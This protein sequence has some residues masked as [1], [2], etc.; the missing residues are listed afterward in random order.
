M[1][2][3]VSFLRVS[4]PKPNMQF[5]FPIFVPHAPPVSPSLIWSPERYLVG[6]TNNEAPQCVIYYSPL[7]LPLSEVTECSPAPCDR[8]PLAYNAPITWETKFHIRIIWEVKLLFCVLESLFLTMTKGKTKVSE[9]N[10]PF[11]MKWTKNVWQKLWNT[12]HREKGVGNNW[13][14]NLQK[15]EK[16]ASTPDRD[17]RVFSWDRSHPLQGP[18]S[19]VFSRNRGHFLR[20]LS[21]R[22][23]KLTLTSIWCRS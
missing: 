12:L 21:G 14:Q 23:V 3:V 8:T 9:E 7:L 11:T 18:Y 6:S 2:Q 10:A 20:R 22:G 15:T 1:F 13:L 5:S 4:E 17:K 16:C 19:L